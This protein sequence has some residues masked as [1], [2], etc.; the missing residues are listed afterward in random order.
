M[1]FSRNWIA[2]YAELPGDTRTLAEAL[3]M[4]G[5]VVDDA[6]PSGEDLVLELDLPSNRPDV[7]N[8]VGIARELAIRLRV[9]FRPPVIGALGDGPDTASLAEV[10][11]EDPSGC[12]RFVACAVLDVQIGE[13]PAWLRERLEAIGLRPINNVVDVTNYVMWELGRPMHAYDLDRLAGHRLRVRRARAGETL[14]TLDEVERRL[15][16]EDLVIA[17]DERPVGLAGVMGGADTG[18]TAQTRRVLL[19]CACFDAVSV[20]RMARRHGLHTDASHRFERGLSHEGILQATVRAAGLLAEFAGGRVAAEVIDARTAAPEPLGLSLR[21]TRLDGYLGTA[22]P[23]AEVREILERLG[24]AVRPAAHGWDV[25]VP[26]RRTDVSREVDLIEEVARFHGYDRLPSTLPLLR[27][28]DKRGASPPLRDERHLRAL[29]AALGYWEA[30]TFVFTA[31]PQ[32]RGFLPADAALLPLANPLSEDMAVLR[33]SLLPGL[34]DAVARNVNRGTDRVRLFEVGRSFRPG[35]GDAPPLERR[36]LALVAYGPA[37]APHWA[38]PARAMAFADLK[39]DVE[40]IG[41]RMG[42]GRAEWTRLD[43]DGFQSGSVARVLW[44]EATGV[45]GK[46]DP[47]VAARYGLET[48]VWAAELDVEAALGRPRTPRPV[49][50][51]PR[52]PASARDVSLLLPADVAYGQVEKVL[53]EQA[54]G[55]PLEQVRLLD[56]YTGEDLPAGHRALTLRLTYRSSESTLTSEQVEAAHEALVAHL[57]QQLGAR[58]R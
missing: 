24:F 35:E 2:A 3:S 50:E 46:V 13:S 1:R 51:L 17:D 36:T 25:S 19:E 44:P 54:A 6:R 20:R 22:V 28:S 32:Q 8:H 7:M 55:L 26:L 10:L 41:R 27:R 40:T 12:T 48:P 34:L 5:L 21:R 53:R 47:A 11:L 57:E 49:A 16:V 29:C 52:F 56:V 43:R 37:A 15:T 39:G 31:E 30:M 45:A 38:R 14:V 58:R 4:L 23:D 33:R 18:V 9:P 42:W